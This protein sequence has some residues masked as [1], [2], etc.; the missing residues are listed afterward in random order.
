MSGRNH[1]YNSIDEMT[2]EEYEVYLRRKRRQ[3]AKRRKLM[4]ERKRKQAMRKFGILSL[5]AAALAVSLLFLSHTLQK[6]RSADAAKAQEDNTS[7]WNR[8]SNTGLTGEDASEVITAGEAASSV[9][10]ADAAVTENL[11]SNTSF[12]ETDATQQIPEIEDPNAQGLTGTDYVD[13]DYAILADADTGEILAEK[14]AYARMVPASMTKVLTLLV[15]AED[16]PEERLDE[17]VTVPQ[18]VTDEAF[19]EGSTNVGYLAGEQTTIRDLFYGAA[20]HSGGDA[21]LELA[22][23][24]AGSVDAFVQEMNDRL[25]ELGLSETAHFTNPVGMYSADHYCTVYDMAVIMNEAMK[26]DFLRTV[27]ATHTYT[28]TPTAEHPEGIEISN[29]FLRKIEDKDCHGRVV[30]AKTGYVDESGNCAV[31]FQQSDSG[32]SYICVTG[33]AAS[34]WR[35]IYD[36]V[37]L[38]DEFTR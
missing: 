34:N 19:R 15:A 13:S 16:I 37:A 10:T 24:A 14:N 12:A 20:L 25:G 27:M 2:D 21:T 26:N 32:G 35:C 8:I 38:Y 7:G 3:Q 5:I 28:V 4:K 29:W 36:H 31:S 9:S 30:A 18:E 11:N 1:S 23:V 6:S 22:Y 17:M 33:K